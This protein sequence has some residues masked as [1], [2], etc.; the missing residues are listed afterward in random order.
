VSYILLL[1]K[2]LKIYWEKLINIL[3]NMYEKK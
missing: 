2:T 3:E 1:R